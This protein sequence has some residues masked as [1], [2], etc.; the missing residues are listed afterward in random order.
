MEDSHITHEANEFDN[1]QQAK[2]GSQ[3]SIDSDYPLDVQAC[4]SDQTFSSLQETLNSD[5]K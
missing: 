2:T 4:C 1:H 5:G 3:Q